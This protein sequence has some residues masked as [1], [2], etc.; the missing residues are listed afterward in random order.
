MLDA[1]VEVLW[2]ARFDYKPHWKLEPHRHLFFQMIYFVSGEGRF[3]LDGR[4][5]AISPGD[6]FLIKPHKTH[7]LRSDSA[8]KTLDVKFNVNHPRWR[9]WLLQ[10]RDFISEADSLFP[11]LLEKIRL[12]GEHGGPL[13][14]EMCR[15]YLTQMLI[16]YLR[17]EG[18]GLGRRDD[19]ADETSGL[20]G[21]DAIS[22]KAVE[23]IKA[24]YAEPITVEDVAWHA[25]ASGRHLRERL[26][27]FSGF[28]PVRYLACCRIDAAKQMLS[29]SECSLKAVAERVGFKDI[30][31]FT[32]VF[33][34]VTGEPPAAWRR[35]Y[36]DGICKDVC[37]DPHFSN[38]ILTAAEEEPLESVRADRARRAS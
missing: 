14:R 19:G 35:R 37:I 28:S 23:Y 3:S 29:R 22:R 31:H 24:H 17:G 38:V 21:C 12:E 10:G 26:K 2:T 15:T 4:E 34:R 6:L 33:H 25:G 5:Y 11:H 18:A 16:L 1:F 7:G 8:V 13:Y 20:T 30:H 36:L 32:R 27:M 9:R